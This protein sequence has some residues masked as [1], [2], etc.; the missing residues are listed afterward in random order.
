MA[1]PVTARGTGGPGA[2]TSPSELPSCDREPIHIPGTIQPHGALVVVSQPDLRIT[3]LSDNAVE[4]LEAPRINPLG[5]QLETLLGPDGARRI[6][7]CLDD[8][9]L[10]ADPEFITTFPGRT[11]PLSVLAHR[12]H[13]HVIV[14]FEPSAENAPS[15]QSLHRVV[16]PF[17]TG[18]EGSDS[19]ARAAEIAAVQVRKITGFD[20]VMVYR[21]DS[22]WNGN[23]IAEDRDPAVISYLNH[24][25]P[26]SDIPAQARELYRLNRLRLIPEARYTPVPIRALEPNAAPLDLTFA[27]LRS[28]SPVHLEYLRNMEARA[29]MSISILQDGQLWG[30]IACHHREPLHVAFET[31]AAC[32]LIG[33]FLS[34]QVVVK[35]RSL[36][37][38]QRLRLKSIQSRLLGYMAREENF[39]DGLTHHPDELLEFASASGAA[40]LF[41]GKCT[42]IGETPN[43]QDV[44]RLAE[45]LIDQG[46][47][48]VYFTDSLPQVIPDGAVYCEKASGLLAISI[49]K[50]FRSYLLWFRPEVMQTQVWAGNPHKPAIRAGESLH[51]R[52]SFEAWE[53]NARG[54]SMPWRDVETDG[55]AELRNS[56]VGIVLR[57]AEELGALS[58]ELQRSNKELESFSYSVSHDLRAPFRH[59]VGYAELLK[60]SQTAQMSSEDR[61]YLDVII[62]SAYTAGDLVDHLLNYSRIGRMRVTLSDVDM[63]ALVHE[64]VREYAPESKGRMIRWRVGSLPVSKGDL[65]LL[66]VVWQNLLGNAFKY[67]SGREVA[68]IEVGCAQTEDEQVFFVKDNGVG[69]DPQYSDKLF[70]VF[71]RL[72]RVDEF[73]GT[74]IGLANVRRIVSRHGGRTW[75]EG[76]LGQGATFYFSLP[77]GVHQESV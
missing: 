42:L 77:R 63:T 29:S 47:E 33:Q 71:Q 56:I 2:M 20:R 39:I 65:A 51:P 59:I 23:V 18:I 40:V 32:D 8:R 5:A 68:R 49:S 75:A 12:H 24:W 6:A 41:E 62:A 74:G 69:F 28:V 72:H 54:R 1:A 76:V 53:E 52:V 45:W 55:A 30:L 61:R 9:P 50:L 21:F 16:R 60:E 25:F 37:Y 48:E 34:G 7:T 43:E 58:A 15:F 73:E 38:E 36:A 13:G 14:E 44:R 57:K 66:R 26:V 19:P 64:M 11:Q 35:E 22:T 3:H 70:R 4:L 46:R 17:L 27:T 31:R 10:T 67:T